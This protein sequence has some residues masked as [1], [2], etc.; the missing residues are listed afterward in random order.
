MKLLSLLLSKSYYRLLLLGGTVVLL[1]A[2][3]T[4]VFSYVQEQNLIAA[5]APETAYQTSTQPAPLVTEA[6]ITLQQAK[7]NLQR[8]QVGSDPRKMAKAY[9]AV[10]SAHL[11][12]RHYGRALLHFRR[13]LRLQQ[14]LGDAQGAAT[15]LSYLGH[16]QFVQG[17]TGQARDTYQKALVAFA[18]SRNSSGEARVFG[19]LGELYASQQA[20]P[21]ALAAYERAFATWKVLGD[22]PEQV[23]ALNRIGFAMAQ[24]HHYSR[25]LYYLHQ[26]LDGSSALHDSARTGRTFSTMGSIYQ[27]MGSY[28]LAAGFY[29]QA[30]QNM[31]VATPPGLRATTLQALATAHDSLHD[32]A[33]AAH[34]LL[35]AIPAARLDR[36]KVLL[37]NLYQNLAAV[38]EHAH[39]YRKSVQALNQYNH[40]QDSTFAEQRSAQIAELQLRYETEKKEREIQLLTKNRQL[41]EAALYRQK[42]LLY[43]LATAAVLLLTAVVALYR[44]RQQQLRINSL[45]ARKNDSI[46]RQKEELDRINRTKDTLFSVI[47]HDLRT[48]LSS[49]YSLLALI[50]MGTV[51]TERMQAHTDRLTRMLDG[52]LRLLDNLLNWSASQMQGEGARSERLRLDALIEETQA[53]LLGDA[54]R[55]NI[56]LINEVREPSVVRADLNMT[57]LILRNLLS[58]AIKFTP[59]GGTVTVSAVRRSAMWEIA[60]TD[61]G[62]GIPVADQEKIFGADEPHSTLGTDKEKGTGLGLRLCKDFVERNGGELTFSSRVGWGS[63]FRF[64][65]HTAQD[66]VSLHSLQ[67]TEQE[68]Q[69]ESEANSAAG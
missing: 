45:L 1:V 30:V 24:Q 56:L 43:L 2:F 53:F 9:L 12:L 26:A 58:N 18:K 51:P 34:Y 67:T 28:E 59:E 42:I 20:W 69:T 65:L 54:D 15:A 29:K 35:E 40:L 8:A 52:T 10:G 21:K 61:T 55:K 62:V 47:S 31:P 25:A 63:T 41:Q 7:R 48:P 37:S 66:S 32:Q 36:S 16:A 44:N 33:S 60:V 46:Q 38:Y 49:L 22:D 6:S 17:D 14:Q 27:A 57:R 50:N 68:A 23:T 3:L 5:P 13:A 4:V 11:S 19:L 39:E 64:T